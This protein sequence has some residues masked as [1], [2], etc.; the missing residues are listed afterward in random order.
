M[1]DGDLAQ[2][3]AIRAIGEPAA[4]ASDKRLKAERLFIGD[5]EYVLYPDRD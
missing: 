5:R 3:V 2:G 1:Q 4:D